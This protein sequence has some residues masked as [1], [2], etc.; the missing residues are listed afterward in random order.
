MI[1]NAGQLASR[2]HGLGKQARPCVPAI[3]IALREPT[4]ALSRGLPPHLSPKV[5]G[6]AIQTSL[7]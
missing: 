7:P 3:I 1:V 5:P 4:F 2:K 6:R